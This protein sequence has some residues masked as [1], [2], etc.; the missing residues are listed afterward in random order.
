VVE[1]SGVST[2]GLNALLQGTCAVLMPPFAEGCGLP[3][4]ETLAADVPVIASDIPSFRKIGGH[5][6]VALRRLT[7][8]GCFR[9]AP[10]AT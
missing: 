8:A 10:P 5:R 3:V 4:I 6:L 2:P 1:V 9:V 7:M